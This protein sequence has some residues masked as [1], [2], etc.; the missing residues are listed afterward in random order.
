MRQLNASQGEGETLV[1]T[2]V[3][4]HGTGVRGP[5]LE[6]LAGRVRDGLQRAAPQARL[7]VCDWGSRHGATLA[8]DGASIP[9]DGVHHRGLDAAAAAGLDAD[10]SAWELLYADPLAELRLAAA[11]GSPPGSVPP[12]QTPADA[13][14]RSR[15]A[16]LTA[17]PGE[18]ETV[19]CL[20]A[21]SHAGPATRA[22]LDAPELSRAAAAVDADTLA[23]LTARALVAHLLATASE[24]G[25][26]LCPT[27]HLRDTAVDTLTVRLGGR[28]RGS[29][30][31][32]ARF[33]LR[34]VTPIA[35]RAVVRRRESITRAAHPA[36]GDILRYL[37]RGEPHRAH[38]ADL[39]RAQPSPVVL[40]CHSLGGIIAVDALVEHDLP[41]VSLLVTAG[42][43]AP[44]LY[45]TGALPSLHYP[46]PLPHS[47]PVWL[48]I[49][50]PRDLLA[51]AA[52]PLFPAHATDVP[53]P[54]GQPFPHSHSAYWTNPALY[55]AVAQHLP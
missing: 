11:G 3:F 17:D 26:P 24:S 37:A 47:F 7:V 50:D 33:L 5:A 9:A 29:D 16:E 32:P 4:V 55:E 21:N 52:Q 18:L 10:A 15:L 53:L 36:A 48:N 14:I 38:L 25:D 6:A 49:H 45:E 8:A 27:A 30:R 19:L 35:S 41:A 20:T 46:Q 54:S 28:P 34:A 39:V 1:T 22:L 31:G 2:V 40:L 42:S 23:D 44:F 13:T 12:H 43:Q 51:F